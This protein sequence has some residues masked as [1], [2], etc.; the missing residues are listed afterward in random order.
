M[1][2]CA[3][4]V[5]SHHND[6]VT[7]PQS[8][9]TDMRNRRN[10]NRDR[11]KRGLEKNKDPKPQEFNPQGSYAM[12]TMVQH[13][14]KDYDIDD[15]IYFNKD[16]LKGSGGADK[17]AL[18]ARQMVRD[19]VDDG[20]F[21]TKPEVRTNCVRIYYDAGYYVDMPVYRRVVS[22]DWFG[23]EQIRYELASADWKRSDARDVTKWFK[24]ENTRQSP[25]ETNGRQLR[26]ICRKIK[27]FAQSR[28]SWKGR[29]ASGFMITKLVTE[30]YKPNSSREDKALYYTMLAI[31]DR[32]EGNLVVAHP[33][34]PNETITKGDSDPK[35]RFLK[36]KLSDA[37][38]WLGVLF[39]DDCTQEEA[40]KAWDKVYNTTYFTDKLEQNKKQSASAL[41]SAG[42]LSASILTDRGSSR[43]PDES[44]RRIVTPQ[45]SF[46][47]E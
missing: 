21:K 18:A 32:L 24:D 45:P 46:G 2:D 8:E 34:T 16:D 39:K 28:S 38:S 10:A 33:V 41:A 12:K 26:R 14:E 31:R 5:L 17:S 30:C 9:R 43:R 42:T 13:P 22:K 11:V 1:F 35:A 29:I 7:L 27:K 3:K 4:E 36:E 40:F 6:E 23:N 19:A 15:G 20:S 37:L 25:D 47:E 44:R